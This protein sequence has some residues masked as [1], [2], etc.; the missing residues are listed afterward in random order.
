MK[1]L[2]SAMT[3]LHGRHNSRLFYFLQSQTSSAS[4]NLPTGCQDCQS[5]VTRQES[6]RAGPPKDFSDHVFRSTWIRCLHPASSN[7]YVPYFPKRGN[8]RRGAE[9]IAL[10]MT[11]D[12]G[13]LEKVLPDRRTL[14]GACGGRPRRQE[15]LSSWARGLLRARRHH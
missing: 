1:I 2:L 14:Q 11:Q 4:S 9:P 6:S 12:P 5:S 10:K 3:T 15:M 13:N 8:L 7:R